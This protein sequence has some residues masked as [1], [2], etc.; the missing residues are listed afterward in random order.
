L[1]DFRAP[2]IRLS[3]MLG[4]ALGAAAWLAAG[5]QDVLASTQDRLAALQPVRVGEANAGGAPMLAGAPLFALSIGPNAVKDPVVMV[6]GLSRMPGR[7]AAL[8]AIDGKPAAW[9][10]RGESRDGAILR[11]VGSGRAT[12]DLPLGMKDLR[13]GEATLDTASA[14]AAV[15]GASVPSPAASDIPPPGYRSPPPPASA[16]GLGG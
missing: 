15:P 12:F 8:V 9:L 10:A 14:I 16:P 5:R 4:L 6:L 2:L 3:A 13:I 7:T 1:L 11:E